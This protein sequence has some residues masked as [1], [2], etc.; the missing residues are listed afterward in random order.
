MELDH[1]KEA[2]SLYAQVT[3]DL[4]SKIENGEYAVGELIPSERELQAIYQVSR[5]TVRLALNEL[6]NR[7]YVEC[8]R[9]IGTIVTYGK[10]KENIRQVKSLTEEMSQQGVEMKTTFCVVNKE[11]LPSI[12]ALQFGKK[13]MTECPVLERVRNAKGRPLVYSKTYLNVEGVPLDASLYQDSLYALLQNQMH[14]TIARG[15]DVL[16]AVLSEGMVSEKLHLPDGYPVFKRTRVTYSPQETPLEYSICYYP[17]DLYK[18]S[19]NI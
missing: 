9:G 7:S 12:I 16:E 10:I 19:V 18:C 11:K 5:M 17:G 3:R 6:V 8:R 2:P 4:S 15:E 1:R 13:P 14:I